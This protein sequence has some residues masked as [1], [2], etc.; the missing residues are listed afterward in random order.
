L[1]STVKTVEKR[2]LTPSVSPAGSYA[3]AVRAGLQ[4]SPSCPKPV[5]LRDLREIYVQRADVCAIDAAKPLD[6]IV[7]DVNNEF[8]R[9]GIGRILSARKLQSGDLILLADSSD[10]KRRAEAKKDEWLEAVGTGAGV[11]HK[12]YTVYVHSVKV[13]SFGTA[14]QEQGIQNL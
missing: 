2:V 11:R 7:K 6:C 13:G 3:G 8:A 1:F 9:F 5:P 10:T 14:K 4:Q 12:R